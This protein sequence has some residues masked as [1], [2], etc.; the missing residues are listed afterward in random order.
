MAGVA[1]VSLVAPVRES[2]IVV[3]AFLS[4]WVLGEKSA[5]RRTV[6]AVIVLAG[7]AGIVLG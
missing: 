5:A 2:S 1:P 6:G 4:W 3:G 7:I